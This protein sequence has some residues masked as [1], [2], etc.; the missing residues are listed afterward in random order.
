M[1]WECNCSLMSKVKG[2]KGFLKGHRRGRL[3]EK[4]LKIALSREDALC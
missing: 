1:S 4:N 3:W 2:R